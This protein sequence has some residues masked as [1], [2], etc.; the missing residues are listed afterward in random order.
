MH[1]SLG[2]RRLCIFFG[3]AYLFPSFFQLVAA[4]H[5]D[6]PSPYGEG[7]APDVKSVEEWWDVTYPSF[8]GN[9][10]YPPQVTGVVDGFGNNASDI[11]TLKA[12][13]A[14][15]F[16]LRIM[17]L[18]ASIT[19]GVASSNGNGYRKWLRQQLRWKGWKVNM[20]GSKANGNMADR[21]NEGHPG[22]VITQVHDAFLSVA[23]TKPNLVLINVGTN[24]CGQNLDTANAGV[25]MKSMIDDIYSRVPG[26][27]V[28]LSTLVKSKS[29][30]ACAA[31]LSQQY[32]NLVTNT[33]S[34]QR[35]GLADIY[36]AISMDQVSGDGIHPTDD[37]YKLFAAVWWDAIS[38]LEDVIQPPAS[39]GTVDDSAS[40]VSNCAKVAGNARGPVRTQ[41]GSGHDDGKY[42]HNRVERGALESARIQKNNDP[43]TI[44]QQIPLNMFFANI[45]KNDPNADRASALDDW[46]RIFRSI[47]GVTTY[48]MRQNLGGGKFGASTVIDFGMDC[49]YGSGHAF[50]DL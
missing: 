47:E 37:G 35:I 44:T 48:Y 16:Y 42:V 49:P 19:E 31:N 28:V 33:Y 8:E 11:G 39:D 12:R 5:W 10:S 36:S 34:G 50:G 15:D 29:N 46:I 7:F 4:Q 40:G 23:N 13:D 27:T 2:L 24:D 32:R 30:D 38:R 22:W 17:P 14:K 21:D 1:L 6:G 18:G 41:V 3:L 45:V 20:V 43:K 26:V 25:R 9:S